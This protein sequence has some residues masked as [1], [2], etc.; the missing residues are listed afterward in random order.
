[1]QVAQ[2]TSRAPRSLVGD[3]SSALAPS[4]YHANL[5]TSA[6]STR[7]TATHLW[8]TR[9]MVH[10]FDPYGGFSRVGQ[11]IAFHAVARGKRK[12]TVVLTIATMPNG[13][14]TRNSDEVEM[15]KKGHNFKAAHPDSRG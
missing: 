12:G 11:V 10:Y 3:K 9:P 6:D 13:Q 7:E 4:A 8:A 2:K 1:M 5:T 14:V 15:V